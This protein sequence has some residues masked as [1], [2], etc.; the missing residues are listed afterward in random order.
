MLPLTEW[1]GKGRIA[2]AKGELVFHFNCLFSYK[3]GLDSRCNY[4][5]KQFYCLPFFVELFMLSPS[6]AGVR[7]ATHSWVALGAFGPSKGA[8]WGSKQ[9]ESRWFWTQRTTGPLNLLYSIYSPSL[10]ISIPSCADWRKLLSFS[11]S[12]CLFSLF[13]LLRQTLSPRF[14]SIADEVSLWLP[15]SKCSWSYI[16]MQLVSDTALINSL[17]CAI[18]LR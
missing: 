9:I 16:E 3:E 7:R 8:K 6:P 5:N 14:T 11:L 18:W 12:L 1:H 4:C 10:T 15:G 13:P 2:Q 17:H